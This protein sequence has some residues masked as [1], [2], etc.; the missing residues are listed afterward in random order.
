VSPKT[1]QRAARDNA[2]GGSGRAG[3]LTSAVPA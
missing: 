1:C 2:R 3:R